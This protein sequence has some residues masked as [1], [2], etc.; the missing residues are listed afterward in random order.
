VKVLATEMRRMATNAVKRITQETID[1]SSL[2]D[3]ELK[4]IRR[5]QDFIAQQSAALLR[6][7]EL[8]KEVQLIDIESGVNRRRR[9]RK[10]KR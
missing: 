1:L 5:I 2:T 4:D 9:A 8:V 6:D 10:A 7:A 3:Q